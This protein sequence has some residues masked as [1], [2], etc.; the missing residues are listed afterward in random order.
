MALRDR[1]PQKKVSAPREEQRREDA[2]GS[3][4]HTRDQAEGAVSHGGK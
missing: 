1:R 4:S 2:P 3:N